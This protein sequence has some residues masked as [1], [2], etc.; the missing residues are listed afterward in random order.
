MSD[1][2]ICGRAIVPPDQAVRF[3]SC[4]CHIDLAH[5]R[6]QRDTAWKELERCRGEHRAALVAKDDMSKSATKW[7]ELMDRALSDLAAVRERLGECERQRDAARNE[8]EFARKCV[9]ELT[10]PD[11]ILAKLAAAEKR[12]G[13]LRDLLEDARDSVEFHVQENAANWGE[14]LL[15]KQKPVVEL[16]ERID[17][18]LARTV[19]EG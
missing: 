2:H 11:E 17:A 14:R 5:L 4:E 13:D 12:V 19:G 7:R 18:A 10:L 1:C 9:S 3:P 16:L 8:L 6:D 15:H